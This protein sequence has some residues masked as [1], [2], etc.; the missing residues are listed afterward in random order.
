LKSAVAICCAAHETATPRPQRGDD[1][2]RP[3]DNFHVLQV[4]SV[5]VKTP[6]SS[7]VQSTI[8]RS[9]R[10]SFAIALL[11]LSGFAA[12]AADD[13]P[14]PPRAARSV[15]LG[16]PA[17]KAVAFYNEVR[18]EHSTPGSYFMV[19]G[20][21]HGYF[22]IQEK[23]RGEKVVLFSIW[24]PT[25]GDDAKAVPV[26]KRVEVLKQ[27]EG[28]EVKR[29]GGEGTGGQSF[30]AFDWKV[31]E[32]YRFFVTAEVEGDKTA[33]AGH[34]YLPEQKAWKHLVTFRTRT[35]GDALKGFYSFVEDFRRDTK[36][37]TEARRAT[38]GNGWVLDDEGK[39]HPLDTARFTASNSTWEAKETINAGVA[40]GGK[41]FLETGG[42]TK[43]T[44]ELNATMKRP[45]DQRSSAPPDDLPIKPK[46]SAQ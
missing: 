27:G 22:G 34:I 45:A 43:K 6:D 31:G 11:L 23:G 4:D 36:S 26:E 39:W 35:G 9:L 12:S 42:D 29:F 1:P 37:A 25:K 44:M 32:T 18:V 46:T 15:H 17:P 30:F 10:L 13:A 8:V 5:A 16:Y 21:N 24:D 14:R 2:T 33:F 19:C 28:V 7:R 40:D 41:F 20:F 3:G 38:F